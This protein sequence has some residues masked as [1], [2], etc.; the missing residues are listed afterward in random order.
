MA[1][2]DDEQRRLRAAILA[3]GDRVRHPDLPLGP[4]VDYDHVT[5]RDDEPHDHIAESELPPGEHQAARSR[6]GAVL[7][8]AHR[9]STTRR[10]VEN[11]PRLDGRAHLFDEGAH[12]W[13]A[14]FADTAN[15]SPVRPATC[16]GQSGRRW[17]LG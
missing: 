15:G 11:D 14:P 4:F 10:G 6:R 16:N 2:L 17:T 7:A 1:R 8:A 5:T 13:F 3:L 12:S 9:C